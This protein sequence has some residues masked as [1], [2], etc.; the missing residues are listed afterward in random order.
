MFH[1]HTFT[2]NPL[3][4]AVACK[5]I[6]LYKKERLL[7]KVARISKRLKSHAVLGSFV[8]LSEYHL[9]IPSKVH[10]FSHRL[11]FLCYKINLHGTKVASLFDIRATFSRSRSFLYNWMFL[12]ATAAASG[13]PVNVWP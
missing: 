2:G 6:Q 8:R 12:H 10:Q 7:E 3:A 11:H 13:F 5:N 9:D 1:G 4:A